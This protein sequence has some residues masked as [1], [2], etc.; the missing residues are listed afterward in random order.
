MKTL[1][2]I[3]DIFT[4]AICAVIMII[5]I[6]LINNRLSDGQNQTITFNCSIAEISPDFTPAMREMCRKLRREQR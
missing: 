4:Y 2:I 1:Q 3:I 6:V 5:G